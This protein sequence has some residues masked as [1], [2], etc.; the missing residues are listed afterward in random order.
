MPIWSAWGA[1]QNRELLADC[2]EALVGAVYTDLGH[3]ACR[4]WMAVMLDG[5][6]GQAPTTVVAAG[7]ALAP[8]F[9]PLHTT[10]TQQQEQQLEQQQQQQQQQ[11]QGEG[12]TFDEFANRFSDGTKLSWSVSRDSMHATLMGP[13]DSYDSGVRL[14]LLTM[15]HL[16][17]LVVQPEGVQVLHLPTGSHVRPTVKLTLVNGQLTVQRLMNAVSKAYSNNPGMERSLR[18]RGVKHYDFITCANTGAYNL[19]FKRLTPCSP[20]RPGEVYV[21]T[22]DGD[23]DSDDPDYIAPPDEF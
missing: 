16:Q 3:A 22:H 23:G 2:F 21:T 1:R 11:Q 5:R 19:S 18:S 7:A 14:R 15:Q 20:E 4:R 9:H 17:A 10:T 6:L 12:I 8:P 13:H